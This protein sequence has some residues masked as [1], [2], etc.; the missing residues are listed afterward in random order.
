MENIKR[1]RFLGLAAIITVFNGVCYTLAPRI[2]LP[3]Y[4]IEPNAGAVLGF[5]FLGAGLLT[6]GLILWFQR[7]SREWLALRGLL[8]GASVGNIVGLIISLQA[9]LTGVMNGSGW[10]F[11]VTYAVLLIGYVY[12]LWEGARGPA[13]A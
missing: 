5:R 3:N 8:I 10:L 6:F 2:L 9:T 7:G 11:V 13:A 4:G 1:R 12:F